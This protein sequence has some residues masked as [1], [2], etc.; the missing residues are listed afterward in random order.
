MK[1]APLAMPPGNMVLL[2]MVVGL[3]LDVYRTFF[4]KVNDEVKA[5]G[6]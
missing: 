6:G 3:A 1:V 4:Q 2:I 5:K